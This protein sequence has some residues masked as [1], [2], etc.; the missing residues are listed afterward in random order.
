MLTVR[1]GAPSDGAVVE[2]RD[3]AVSIGGRPVLRHIDLTVPSGEF[4]ALMGAKRIGKDLFHCASLPGASAQEVRQATAA[5]RE[6]ERQ[7]PLD[8]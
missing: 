2:V 8:K 5:C 6:I 4:L 3:V 1:P 7:V